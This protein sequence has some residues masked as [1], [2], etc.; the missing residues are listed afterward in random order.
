VLLALRPYPALLLFYGAGI[1]C[2]ARGNYSFF[3]DMFRLKVRTDRDREEAPITKALNTVRIMHPEMQRALPGCGSQFTPLSNHLFSALRELLREYIPDDVL[4]DETFDWFEY[5]L[6]L[7]H[8]DLTTSRE[9]LT[10]LKA[11][12]GWSIWGPA[13]RWVWKG[14][15]LGEATVQQKADLKHGELFPVH[16]GSLLKAGFF[17]SEERYTDLKRGFD[18]TVAK[19]AERW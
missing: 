7:I 12:E 10:A 19:M 14:G 16:I 15:L 18:T 5:L 3:G 9:D 13:G 17:G 4:F 2:L 1:A 6:S 11:K 8:C